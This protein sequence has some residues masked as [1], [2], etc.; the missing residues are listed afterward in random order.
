MNRRF[1]FALKL[2]LSFVIVILVS[3]A[4]VYFLTARAITSRFAEFREQNKQQVAK[5]ICGLLC[6][7]R[8]RTGT[9]LGIEQLLSTRYTVWINGRLIVRRTSLIGPFSLADV[10]GKVVVSTEEGKVGLFLSPQEIASG[11]PLSDE[12]EKMGVLLLSEQGSVLDPAEE[13]FLASAKRSALLGGGIASGIALL[14]SAFLISQ[15]LSPL[16]LLS[17]ATERI[18]HGDLTQRVALKARDEFG[19]LGTSF[20]RMIDNLRRSETIRQTMTA[21]IAHE[22]RTPVTIIQGNLEAILDGVYQPTA[23]TIAPIY[24]ET[25]HL[26]R[27]IDDLRDL[28]LAEAGELRLNKEPTDLVT[29]VNQVTEMVSSSLERG[30]ELH[31]RVDHSLPK[32]SLDPK[33]IRQV[34]ANILSNALRHTPA[35]GEIWVEVLQEGG[36]VE[37]RV[38]DS[39]PGIPPEDLPH[40]FERFYRGDQAR[41]RSEGGSGLGLAIAKQ[42]VE[43]HGGRI[44]AENNEQTGARFV[45]RLPLT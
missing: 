4:L 7:Y 20:N 43:A 26:G 8:R 37:L 32:V 15:V 36:E 18:A 6:E 21:D 22:L 9:W 42:W 23:E 41:S 29:L 45:V 39:G 3:V 19:Q 30:P 33:R 5:Q 44:W 2:G 24:E 13:E 16:R 35:T 27:L 28:A 34:M 10:D 17:R 25:L 38:T 11:I 31:V 1:P 12:G 40:L 14:L